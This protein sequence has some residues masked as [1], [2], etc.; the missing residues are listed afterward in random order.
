M[1]S[2]A[3]LEKEDLKKATP[4]FPTNIGLISSMSISHVIGHYFD[5]WRKMAFQKR[6]T[7][8]KQEGEKDVIKDILHKSLDKYAGDSIS[9]LKNPGEHDR[10]SSLAD[11]RTSIMVD[12]NLSQPNGARWMSY[13]H[14]K[15]RSEFGQNQI[16]LALASVSNASFKMPGDMVN[17]SNAGTL[18]HPGKLTDSS[19]LSGNN[20]FRELISNERMLYK[21]ALKNATAETLRYV[22]NGETARQARALGLLMNHTAEGQGK[23]DPFAL[24]ALFENPTMGFISGINGKILMEGGDYGDTVEACMP[25]Y[26]EIMEGVLREHGMYWGFAKNVTDIGIQ[27]NNLDYIFQAAFSGRVID[28]FKIKDGNVVDY[29]PDHAKSFAQAGYDAD[30]FGSETFA[31]H[32]RQ[33]V[34]DLFNSSTFDKLGIYDEVSK[35]YRSVHIP[36]SDGTK[37]TEVMSKAARVYMRVMRLDDSNLK[38][39]ESI[40]LSPRA[41]YW[42]A[43]ANE[44]IINK[45]IARKIRNGEFLEGS[46]EHKE[47]LAK[48]DRI[49]M[50][51]RRLKVTRSTKDEYV[52]H[53]QSMLSKTSGPGIV[54]DI[55]G[56][57]GTM[58]DEMVGTDA[59]KMAT[60][61][62][63]QLQR[64][65]LTRDQVKLWQ[66]AMVERPDGRKTSLYDTLCDLGMD[67][68]ALAESGIETMNQFGKNHG[69]MITDLIAKEAEFMLGNYANAQNKYVTP[70]EKFHLTEKQNFEDMRESLDAADAKRGHVRKWK[71]K[72][73]VK[74]RV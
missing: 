63:A 47:W 68:K 20:I 35:L 22:A 37:G 64:W 44:D 31:V 33:A 39:D 9:D 5:M 19:M 61:Y 16:K 18:G 59:D 70:S 62:G 29:N 23:E 49:V 7:Q 60:I 17:T 55:Y 41:L 42:I 72:F 50:E 28:D 54:T 58:L 3:I 45:E 2:G 38:F 53:A 21:E 36:N 43:R 66:A 14:N 26:A 8:L 48:R 67:G 24:L 71:R 30:R 15:R 73:G 13:F 6:N 11:L 32:N 57:G 10:I 51:T 1:G 74:N 25:I 65:N 34:L 27:K 12:L 40:G 52:D 56:A 69:E 4:G 46:A